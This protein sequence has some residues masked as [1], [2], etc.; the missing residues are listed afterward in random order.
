MARNS[1]SSTR[2][3]R[4]ARTTPFDPHAWLERA[5]AMQVYSNA[6]KE[7]DDKVLR[8]FDTVSEQFKRYFEFSAR[9]HLV[10]LTVAI[11]L[12][13]VSILFAFL[14]SEGNLFYQTFSIIGLPSATI[15][16]IF[17]LIKNPLKNARQLLEYTIRVNVVFLSFVRRLQQSDLALRFVFMQSQGDDFDKV[18]L[19]IQEFQNMIDQTN[20]EISQIMQDFGESN[21]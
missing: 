19:Q 20:E 12:L 2:V 21:P 10:T 18:H 6:L 4:S 17:L 15:T 7:A 3:S 5:E 16:L 9:L 11:I 13:A 8:L 1:K 14:S